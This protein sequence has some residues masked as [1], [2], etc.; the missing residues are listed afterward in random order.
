MPIL[1]QV[2]QVLIVQDG[3][4]EADAIIVLAGQPIDRATYAANLYEEGLAPILITTGG[5][6]P[7][8]FEAIGVT[9]VESDIT[10]WQLNKLGVPDSVV[11]QVCYATSTAEEADTLARL[12]V[13]MGLRSCIVVTNAFH[14]RRVK[15]VF[16][17]AFQQ[18]GIRLMVAPAPSSQYDEAEWWAY[19]HGLLAVNNEYVKLLYYLLKGYL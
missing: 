3:I 15:K 9:L 17:K 19:E 16:H 6:V 4:E 1:R 2:G 14:T 12:C 18:T 8:D 5:A 10:K 13:E 7:P 11:Q